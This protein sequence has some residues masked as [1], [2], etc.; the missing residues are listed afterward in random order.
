M[1]VLFGY[2]N[3]IKTRRFSIIDFLFF[4]NKPSTNVPRYYEIDRSI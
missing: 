2:R 3:L 1:I 4:C